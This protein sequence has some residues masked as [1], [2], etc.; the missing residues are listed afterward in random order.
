MQTTWMRDY[1]DQYR[2]TLFDAAVCAQLVDL[3]TLFAQVKSAGGKIIFAG[4]GGSAA[5]ASHCAVDFTKTAGLRSINFNESDLITCFANDYGYENWISKALEMY[6][7]SPDAVVLI[8]SSGKSPNIINAAEYARSKGL[9]LVTFT[10][11]H[12]DNT[13][14]KLGQINF[15]VDSSRYNIVENTHIIWLLAVCDLMI[16]KSGRST[17]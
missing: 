14:R 4:N 12:K 15:W 7:D 1:L 17:S 5:M 9:K 16:A 6:A 10:G 11:F 13:L 2:K 8:S 3:K